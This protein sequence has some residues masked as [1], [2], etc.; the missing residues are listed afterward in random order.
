[1]VGRAEVVMTGW[2]IAWMGMC[3]LFF[4]ARF[5]YFPIVHSLHSSDRPCSANYSVRF[6]SFS[7]SILSGASSLSFIFFFLS[8][9]TGVAEKEKVLAVVRRLSTLFFPLAHWTLTTA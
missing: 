7:I 6:F 3:C 8:G 4:D 1:M 2:G 9:H 5:Y